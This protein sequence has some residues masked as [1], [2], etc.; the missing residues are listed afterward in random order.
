MLLR[1]ILVND[2][3]AGDDF[4]LGSA[5]R[6]DSP[7]MFLRMRNATVSLKIQLNKIRS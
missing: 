3:V 5:S 7:H 2:R 4:L 6:R 1:K